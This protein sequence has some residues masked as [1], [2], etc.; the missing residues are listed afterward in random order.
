MVLELFQVLNGLVKQES[1]ENVTKLT[2]QISKSDKS[3]RCVYWN[4]A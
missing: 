2:V 4:C 3:L 1:I